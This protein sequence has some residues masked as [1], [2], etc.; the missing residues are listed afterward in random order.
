MTL[1]LV[2]KFFCFCLFFFFFCF[3]VV[4]FFFFFFF[5]VCLFVCFLLFSFFLQITPHW[6]QNRYITA[7]KNSFDL[8]LRWVE[9]HKQL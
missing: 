2:L 7:K 9:N 3:F 6:L 8:V 4:F 1:S 5:F